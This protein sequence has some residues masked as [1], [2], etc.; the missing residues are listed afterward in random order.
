MKVSELIERLKTMPQDAEVVK[1]SYNGCSE[2]N[3]EC[4]GYY[5]DIYHAEFKEYGDYPNDETNVVV[6]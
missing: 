1:V 3:G 5:S 6:L 4:F 2:C